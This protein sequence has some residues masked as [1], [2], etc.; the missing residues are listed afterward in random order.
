VD[1]DVDARRGVRDDVD[2]DARRGVRDDVDV[3]VRRTG[4]TFA[5]DVHGSTTTTSGRP[6]CVHDHVHDH[7]HVH[8]HD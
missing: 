4:R 5:W 1:V 7:V 8:V 6:R 2:V 3:D